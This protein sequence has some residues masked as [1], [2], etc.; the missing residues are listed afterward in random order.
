MYV[1]PKQSKR[2]DARRKAGRVHW[3]L[4]SCIGLALASQAQ[5]DAVTDW[6]A[7]ADSTAI[8]SPPIRLRIL[9]MTQIAVHDSLNSIDPRFHSYGVMSPASPTASPEAA[10][11]AATY[12]VLLANY[13]AQAAALA[14]IY[15]A[16][17]AAM[18]CAP[19]HPSCITDGIDAG[20]DAADAIMALRAF[21]GSSTPNL[22]YTP[23][24]GPGVYQSTPPN[25]P[26]PSFEGWAYVTP[27]V[28]TSGSQ[29][30]MG[31][32]DVLNL[33]SSTYTRDYREVKRVGALNASTAD[34]S[35]DQEANVRFW[36]PASWN[37]IARE[38]VN[39]VG[40][41]LW[42][43]AQ[44]FALLNMAQ[45]DALV[46]VYDTKYHYNFWRP[47]TAIRQAATDGNPATVADAG[48]LP[49]L[50]T[51][52]PAYPDYTCGL[53]M[54]VGSAAEVLRRY[55]GSDE[56]PFTLTAG[57]TTRSY[58]SM[59]QAEAA[60]VNARVYGGIHF[61]SGCRLGIIQGEKVG[62]FAI[63]HYLQASR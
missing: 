29:F 2:G 32:S 27:F 19:A 4:G 9:A 53:T 46:S 50:S 13:P 57:G 51:N 1:Q 21:D 34:R 48:W 5:A 31:P 47:V 45:S 33:T 35:D 38:L 18:T 54:V 52:T 6:N 36:P 56:L 12:R 55:F 43:H 11:A 23:L 8:G 63:Q 37:A 44:L 16:R 61:R 41:D 22:P 39:G 25:Y 28:M 62:R 10:V 58:T 30:R 60:A 3:L 24:P 26:T 42:E 7:T 59:S 40:L 14:A 49:Y 20:N 17:I 15:N